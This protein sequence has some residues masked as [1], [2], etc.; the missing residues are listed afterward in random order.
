M[1]KF[2]HRMGSV[3]TGSDPL[4]INLHGELLGAEVPET[5][6]PYKA[7]LDQVRPGAGFLTCTRVSTSRAGSVHI[8]KDPSPKGQR[9]RD[10]ACKG[11]I[12]GEYAV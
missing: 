8:R 4:L 5:W 6:V 1:S 2:I 10:R 7:S 9:A 3:A 12:R 11:L